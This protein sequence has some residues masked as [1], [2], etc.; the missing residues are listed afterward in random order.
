MG[1][2]ECQLCLSG[3]S[4]SQAKALVGVVDEEE[5]EE[6]SPELALRGHREKSTESARNWSYCWAQ[7]S[8]VVGAAVADEAAAAAAAAAASR[9]AFGGLWELVD[10]SSDPVDDPEEEEKAV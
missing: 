3:L 8:S 10:A 9:C 5:E 1:Q 2:A 7:R 4:V 6:E